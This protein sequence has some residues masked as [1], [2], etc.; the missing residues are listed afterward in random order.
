VEP[1]GRDA[2][3]LNTHFGALKEASD[4]YAV[5]SQSRPGTAFGVELRTLA[6][7]RS[8]MAERFAQRLR[9]LGAAPRV[10]APTGLVNVGALLDGDPRAGAEEV[11][12]GERL[13]IDEL[14]DSGH[15]EALSGET[16]ALLL[17]TLPALHA[18]A[19]RVRA[20]LHTL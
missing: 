18:Q 8:A 10:I 7:A 4:S 9:E 13:L 15:D 17:S 19:H 5:A 3:R 2:I 12:R 16:R 6:V 11:L 14:T 1:M 20:F